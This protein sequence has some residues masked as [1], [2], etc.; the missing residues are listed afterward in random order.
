VTKPIVLRFFIRATQYIVGFRSFLKFLFRS[1]V[2]RIAVGVMLHGYFTIRFLNL[3]S[4]GTFGH[5]QHL[6]IISF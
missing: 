6:V 2:T 3:V 4:T 5:T 1:F